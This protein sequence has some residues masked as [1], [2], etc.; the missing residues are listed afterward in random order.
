MERCTVSIVGGDGQTHQVEVA[1]ASLFDAVNQA[2]EQRARLWW[3]NPGAVVDVRAGQRRWK[4]R[5]RRVISWR[6]GKGRRVP[7]G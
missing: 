6:G 2:M 4:V 1:A 5:L 7:R 3:F